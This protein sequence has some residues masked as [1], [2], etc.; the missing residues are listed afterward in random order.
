MSVG[1]DLAGVRH[2]RM[3]RFMDVMADASEP[4]AAIRDDAPP[5]LPAV[6]RRRDPAAIVN[7]VTLSTMHGCPPDEIERIARYCLEERGLHTVVKLNP[8]LL[9]REA[10]LG[11]LHDQ[12]GFREIRIPD[13]VFDH[14]LQ[15]DRAVALIRALKETAARR[16]LTFGVKLSNTLAMSNHAAR[17]PGG[18]MYMS[19]RALYPVTMRL[20]D[21][22]L[23]EF[24][25]DLHVSFSAGADAENVARCSGAAHCPSPDAPTC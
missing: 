9:G 17:L 3:T 23:H 24:G 4:L 15:Y 16:G 6:R 21:R 19:G 2:P 7:S 25:G 20:Y 10:V 12:L 8:T 22:L 11:I 18:E 5:R 14:D 13:A 1:Y